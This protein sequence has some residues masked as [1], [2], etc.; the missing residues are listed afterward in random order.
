[1]LWS[2]AFA[3]VF[4]I[5]ALVLILRNQHSQRE[6]FMEYFGVFA[7]VSILLPTVS[8][9]LSTMTMAETGLT[10][11]IVMGAVTLVCTVIAFCLY[12]AA[13]K[14]SEELAIERANTTPR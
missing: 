8:S 4:I 10:S 9:I 13:R 11:Y 2:T 7:S 5:V 12:P 6:R 3:V 14:A 1:M